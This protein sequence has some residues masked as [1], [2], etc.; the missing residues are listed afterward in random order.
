MRIPGKAVFVIAPIAI[1]AV[2]VWLVTQDWDQRRIRKNLDRLAAAVYKPR[3]AVIEGMDLFKRVAI[4]QSMFTTDCV[5][6]AGEPAP[7]M[8]GTEELCGLFAQGIKT[9]KELK[10]LF[11]DVS[12]TVAP[13]HL[14]A[15]ATMTVEA[16]GEDFSEGKRKFDAREVEAAWK[17]IEGKWK[18]AEVKEVQTLH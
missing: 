6:S 3:G 13:D 12:V 14:S 5:I 7:E 1:A 4:I 17:K 16:I 18:I 11:K 9:V 2:V 8:K 10:I 15:A